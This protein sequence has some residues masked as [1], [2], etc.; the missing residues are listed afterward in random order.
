MLFSFSLTEA[1][2]R[3]KF[4]RGVGVNKLDHGSPV[5]VGKT[6][7]FVLWLLPKVE[8]FPRA[9]RFTVG[10]FFRTGRGWCAA[11]WCGSDGG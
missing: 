5:A 8:N 6:Y 4:L 9:H 1:K 7:D 2:P 3:S 11:T 10:G